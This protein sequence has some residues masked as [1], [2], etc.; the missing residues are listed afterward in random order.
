MFWRVGG[1]RPEPVAGSVT[2]IHSHSPRV[3]LELTVRLRGGLL[4]AL[5]AGDSTSCWRSCARAK[6]AGAILDNT[7]RL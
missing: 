6:S 4:Q 5:D 1:F 7:Y 2:R 3:D